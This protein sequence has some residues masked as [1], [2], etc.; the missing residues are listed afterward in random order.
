M[1]IEVIILFAS[2][3]LTVFISSSQTQWLFLGRESWSCSMTSLLSCVQ[4]RIHHQHSTWVES[5]L[6][7]WSSCRHSK[8][9]SLSH[10]QEFAQVSML[11]CCVHTEMNPLPRYSC[12]LNCCRHDCRF[13]NQN[14]RFLLLWSSREA[15][16][17]STDRGTSAFSAW[18]RLTGQKKL[19]PPKRP[20]SLCRWLRWDTAGFWKYSWARTKPGWRLGA[21]SHW[22]A[23]TWTCRHSQ[24]IFASRLKE[25]EG[26]QDTE[27]ATEQRHKIRIVAAI[28]QVPPDGRCRAS[29]F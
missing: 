14:H 4:S 15:W 1:S 24:G 28:V 7:N 13:L 20:P 9:P 12:C 29:T 10:L 25:Q 17:Y 21:R 26:D 11:D 6:F 16:Y 27:I 5:G 3:K 22:E 2:R 19:M 23:L 8:V 18:Q